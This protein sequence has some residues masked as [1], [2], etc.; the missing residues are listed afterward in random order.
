MNITPSHVAPLALL[1]L[2][3][4]CQAPA[5]ERDPIQ[6]V[7]RPPEPIEAPEPEP[8][9]EVV[10][11]EAPDAEEEELADE[12]SPCPEGMVYVDTVYCTK[13]QQHCLNPPTSNLNRRCFEYAEERTCV[14]TERRQRFCID[15]YE[16]PNQKGA[17]SPVMLNAAQAAGLCHEQ[18]KRLC[19]ESE[20]TAACE[21]REKT[22]YPYG[23]ERDASKCNIDV[24]T[25][26]YNGRRM[27]SRS[28]RV[29]DAEL[30]RV[31]RAH[32][33]GAKPECKSDLGVYDQGGNLSEWVF[34]ERPRGNC[35][36][37]GQKGGHWKPPIRNACRP[38]GVGHN[39]P[40]SFYTLGVRCCSD[41]DPEK[42]AAIDEAAEPDAKRPPTWT[43][44]KP[45][46]TGPRSSWRQRG[47]YRGWT[48][49]FKP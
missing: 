7:G 21:G 35:R 25:P 39:E 43:P 14:G 6:P 29:R 18:G 22:P 38:T 36:W 46:V 30:R 2:L 24:P 33:A 17:W 47:V 1:A 31:N 15:R 44:P 49:D 48:P 42:L 26:L 4:A 27:R 3:A 13:V 20:W 28:R 5:E 19:W 40:W 45:P 32:R 10:E 41:P 37:A 12:E 23:R 8:E 34:L 16:Y 11:E 9:P